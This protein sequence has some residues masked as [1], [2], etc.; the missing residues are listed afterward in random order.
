MAFDPVKELDADIDKTVA[1]ARQILAELTPE[2]AP[3]PLGTTKVSAENVKFDYDHREVD[4]WPKQFDSALQR[5]VTEG[6]NIGWAWIE[7]LKHDK[8]LADGS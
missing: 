3:H 8:E 4:Y 5:A 2:M 6:K 1:E 7:T